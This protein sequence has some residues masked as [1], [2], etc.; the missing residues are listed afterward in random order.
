LTQHQRTARLD[1]GGYDEAEA[2]V[3]IL[4]RI[5]RSHHPVA[6][7]PLLLPLSKIGELVITRAREDRVVRSDPMTTSLELADRSLSSRHA[8][9][10]R[11]MGSKRAQYVLEDLHSTNGCRVND[12]RIE[13]PQPLVHGDLVEIG[14]SFWC[15][16]QRPLGQLDALLALA[17]S[18]GPISY[19]STVSPAMLLVLSALVRV[20]PTDLSLIICGES[21]TGKEGMAHELHQRSG[22]GGP[23][24]ALNCAAIPEGLVESELFGH[25]K[26]AFT[27]AVS[28]KRGLIEEAHQGT[29]LLD[30]VGDMPLPAQA[31]LLRVLQERSYVRLGETRNKH[32]DVRFVASTHHDLRQMVDSEQFRGD[33]YARLNG[34]SLQLPALR[35]RRED[36]G[37]LVAAL[38]RRQLP[39]GAVKLS[40]RAYRALVHHD[41]P[42][43]IRELEKALAVAAAFAEGPCLELDHLPEA[44]RG[45]AG[46]GAGDPGRRAEGAAEASAGGA[47]YAAQARLI[48]NRS[49]GWLKEGIEGVSLPA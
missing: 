44:V 42:F 39:T 34:M 49:G 7:D 13:A 27:G 48:R 1:T 17:Y 26:G 35:D 22:R 33:L 32:V 20:A 21:G 2:L 45:R 47:D 8:R 31:K 18:G 28:D 46:P 41:W 4:I 12:V 24:V 19:A 3:P 38:L 43:N 10:M 6:A 25:R 23:L 16:W 30:E 36:I 37:L 40:H 5:G 14:Q 9:L 11:L 15:F 29:L